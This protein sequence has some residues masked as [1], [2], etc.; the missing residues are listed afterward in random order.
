MNRTAMDLGHGELPHVLFLRDNARPLPD[1][2][3]EHLRAFP[4]NDP[5]LTMFAEYNVQ[6]SVHWI[7]MSS[8]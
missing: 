2:L 4:Y 8:V 3:A 7:N 5:S 1:G 6:D